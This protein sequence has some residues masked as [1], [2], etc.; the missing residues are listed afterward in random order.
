MSVD[1]N[2]VHSQEDLLDA[3]EAAGVGATVRLTVSQG[4]DGA[5]RDVK[6]KLDDLR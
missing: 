2:R 1:G 6:M 5:R 3:F 4:G